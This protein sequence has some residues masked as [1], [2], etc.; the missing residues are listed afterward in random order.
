MVYYLVSLGEDKDMEHRPFFWMRDCGDRWINFVNGKW[1]MKDASDIIC[2]K[3]DIDDITE[4]DWSV[5][6]L[7]NKDSKSG[8][9]SREGRFY[10]CPD[11]FHDKFAAYVL[12]IKVDEL[13][14]T[15]WARILGCNNYSSTRQLSRE[16]NRWL[17]RNGYRVYND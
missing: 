2:E 10:G 7:Y 8:W 17:R 16:Q 1:P 12:G 3:V 5:T 9:L 15:G 6:P 13:E 14:T 4:L 11:Y